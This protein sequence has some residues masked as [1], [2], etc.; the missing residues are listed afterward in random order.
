MEKRQR[1]GKI[2]SVNVCR[3]SMNRIADCFVAT[4]ELIFIQK[5]NLNDEL[6]RGDG[7]KKTKCKQNRQ[8][9]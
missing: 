1:F 2:S 9:K 6:N 4:T 3:L 5:V 8:T 7:Q